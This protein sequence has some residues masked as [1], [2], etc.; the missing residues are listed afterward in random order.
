MTSKEELELAEL[1]VKITNATW[2][3]KLRARAI[4]VNECGYDVDR[5]EFLVCK[6]LSARERSQD[7]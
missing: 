3:S 2:T 1:A 4:L 5:A 6:V 7:K